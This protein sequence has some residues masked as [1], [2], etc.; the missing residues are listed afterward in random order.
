[1]LLMSNTTPPATTPPPPDLLRIPLL[2]TSNNIRQKRLLIIYNLT[3]LH[4]LFV[5][6]NHRFMEGGKKRCG[7]REKFIT[8]HTENNRPVFASTNPVTDI[9]TVIRNPTAY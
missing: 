3:L 7:P 5:C 6:A 2:A 8:V 4:C 1:M 9:I